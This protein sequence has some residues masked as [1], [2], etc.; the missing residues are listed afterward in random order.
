MSSKSEQQ[1]SV[2]KNPEWFA[3]DAEEFIYQ[4]KYQKVHVKEKIDAKGP[5]EEVGCDQSPELPLVKDQ[6]IIEIER[7][8]RNHVKTAG[9]R[10]DKGTC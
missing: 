5:K 2:R 3:K 4:K 7:E 8:G 10:G 6:I 1:A 9:R